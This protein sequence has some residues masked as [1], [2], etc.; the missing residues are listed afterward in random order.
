MYIIIPSFSIRN[1]SEQTSLTFQPSLRIINMNKNEKQ[2]SVIGSGPTMEG[3][4]GVSQQGIL[5]LST[6]LHDP[7]DLHGAVADDDT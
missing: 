1:N 3:V 2:N 5:I 7:P 4:E 6:A